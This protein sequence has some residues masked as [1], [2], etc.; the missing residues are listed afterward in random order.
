MNAIT[1]SKCIRRDRGGIG[2]DYKNISSL[3]NCCRDS[4]YY[5]PREK[6]TLSS[7]KQ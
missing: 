7:Q 5:I 6:N 4:V 3:T 2:T 1:I